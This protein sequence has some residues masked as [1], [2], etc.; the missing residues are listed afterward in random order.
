MLII[1]S[2]YHPGFP[3]IAYVDSETGE[4]Q[5]RRL[6]HPEESEKFCSALWDRSVKVRV[7]WKP[8]GM[9]AGSNDYS[10]S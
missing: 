6:K 5:E 9:P 2:D 10:M 3:Q 4:F 8:V 7:V 1:G